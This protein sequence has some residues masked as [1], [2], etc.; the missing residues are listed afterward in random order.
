MGELGLKHGRQLGLSRN[1]IGTT[2]RTTPTTSSAC[3][4]ELS[5]RAQPS[6]YCWLDTATSNKPMGKGHTPGHTFS[7][8]AFPVGGS[9]PK[10]PD[11]QERVKS[12]LPL[13][14]LRE[15]NIGSLLTHVA[16][17]CCHA[18]LVANESGRC[19]LCE[20]Q[21]SV[22]FTCGGSGRAVFEGVLPR[23]LRTCEV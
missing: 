4:S 17:A 8:G 10:T 12:K 16:V 11:E 23:C 3:S 5:Q 18:G 15:L 19:Q 7:A 13:P 6:R 9:W 2:A 20:A 22:R 21:Y 14:C 1:D